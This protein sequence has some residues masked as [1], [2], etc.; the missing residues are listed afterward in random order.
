MK[1]TTEK[2]ANSMV[3]LDVELD[4]DQVERGLDRAAQRLSQNIPFL[5][6]VKE[7]PRVL[8]SKN[9]LDGTYYLKKPLRILFAAL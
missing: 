3:A 2:L 7:K 5:G 6:F 8:L 9:F 4:S 1:I